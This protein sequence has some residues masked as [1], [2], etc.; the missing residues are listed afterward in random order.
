M[1]NLVSKTVDESPT[2]LCSSASHSW[3]RLV[4]KISNRDLSG[5][6][7]PVVR[8]SGE[9]I[10]SSSHVWQSSVNPNTSTGRLVAETTKNPIGTKSSHNDQSQEIYGIYYN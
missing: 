9:N 5:L 7:K 8:D 6:A 4:A 10:A 1:R 2:T 3:R